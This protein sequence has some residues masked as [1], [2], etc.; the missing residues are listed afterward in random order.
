MDISTDDLLLTDYCLSSDPPEVVVRTPLGEEKM[1]SLGPSSRVFTPSLGIAEVKKVHIESTHVYLITPGGGRRSYQLRGDELVCLAILRSP[2]VRGD[3]LVWMDLDCEIHMERFSCPL[4]ALAASKT[5]PQKGTPCQISAR[6]LFQMSEDQRSYLRLRYILPD[7]PY[8]EVP[9][10][11]RSL[12]SV[13]S[14]VPEEYLKNSIEVRK[15]FLSG[16]VDRYATHEGAPTFPKIRG[17]E[18]LLWSLG[19]TFECEAKRILLKGRTY[20]PFNVTYEG[21]Q[22]HM[23]L[24][25]EQ[26]G[27]YLTEDFSVRWSGLERN[28]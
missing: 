7:Y 12:A 10:L 28:R 14:T 20:Y 4:A 3:H 13:A 21:V 8:R 23:R 18:K 19:I 11:P 26:P 1:S 27:P 16:L 15:A 2:E 9:L 25:L 24:E 17:V 5:K 22:P 6:A